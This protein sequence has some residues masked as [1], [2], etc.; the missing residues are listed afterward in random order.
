MKRSGERAEDPAGNCAW[1]RGRAARAVLAW[2]GDVT[3]PCA[4]PRMT[5]GID[6][7]QSSTASLAPV[8]MAEDELATVPSTEEMQNEVAAGLGRSQKELSP[9]YF[10]DARGAA[11][12]EEITRLPEYYLTRVERA[13]LARFTPAWLERVRPGALVEL[14]AGSAD[15]TRVLLA[16]MH[17]PGAHYVP[18]DISPSFLEGVAVDIGRE[19]PQLEVVPA[20]ADIARHLV[21]PAPLPHPVVFAFL[22]STIGNFAMPAAHRLLADVRQHMTPPDRFLMGVDLVKD[23]ATLE[24]A[25]NDAAGV[26]AAFNRNILH[27]LNHELGADFDPDSFGHRAF[28]NDAAS[29]IEMHLESLVDQTIAIPGVG[30]V[31]LYPGESIRTEISRKYTRATVERLFQ[32]AGL[33]L[34]EWITDAPEAYALVVGSPAT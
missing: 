22:G 28:Y 23:V 2:R 34:E 24:A 18:V 16:A 10:Y 19:F 3:P 20:H 33:L 30:T 31:H 12:F 32:D 11:L 9:K 21:I 8:A 26:T 29:R 7:P 5:V 25:Y 15:K 14:G 17:R 13:L 6:A 27:V 1:Q 4:N